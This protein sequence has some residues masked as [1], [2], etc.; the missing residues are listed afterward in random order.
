MKVFV[1]STH[2]M[3]PSHYETD[4][5][6]IENHIDANDEI[7]H[8]TCYGVLKS[9]D[10]N[11]THDFET[12]FRCADITNCGR[13]LL[14]KAVT[15]LPIIKLNP[16]KRAEINE[17]VKSHEYISLEELQNISYQ[18]FDVGYGVSSSLISMN[19]DSK[20]KL[21]SYAEETFN[22]MVS[23]IEVY[24]S[25]LSYIYQIKPDKVYA[26]NGRFS[27]VK[28]I[29]RACQLAGV[30]CYL[31][32]R[33]ADMSKYYLWKDTIPHDREYTV[34][35]IE[36]Y[37]RKADEN[38]RVSIG[39]EFYKERVMGK[40]QGW[41]SFTK[42]QE[43]RLPDNWDPKKKNIIIFNS[44]EDEFASVG[45]EWKNPVYS[46]QIT[47]IRA[48]LED[49][50]FEKDI[51]IYL[52]IHPN[53]KDVT[54]EYT[55][56]LYNLN[57]ENLTILKPDSAISSYELLFNASTVVTFGSTMGIEAVY[58]GIP[59]ISVGVSMYSD[60]HATY[61][62]VSHAEII[63]LIKSE[64]RPSPCEPALK[65]GFFYKSFGIDYKLYKPADILSGQFKTVNIQLQFSFLRSVYSKLLALPIAN[66]LFR[67]FER[68][69]RKKKWKLSF[70]QSR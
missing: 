57:C 53:L 49:L 30:T 36:D 6:I 24:E 67:K 7:F 11:L 64:L 23:S 45:P 51:C 12:C 15:T 46:D 40:N 39:E 42:H 44:S 62:P 69:Y 41:Y 21:S 2:P 28:A 29:L 33:G 37:W 18:N 59:S 27:H 32:D 58:W 25:V 60:L 65:Y 43:K 9:C 66:R 52:R 5:E 38:V 14:S 35:I 8:F 17:F 61:Q 1:F 54:D 68:T 70:L 20:P 56:A 13:K 4:L 19:R 47:G 26:F 10:M 63:E 50:Q 48:I 16:K 31:H 34:K 22:L 55:R 3:W